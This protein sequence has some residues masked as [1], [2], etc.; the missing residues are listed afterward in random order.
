MLRSSRL[1][2]EYKMLV[3]GHEASVALSEAGLR[4]SHEISRCCIPGVRSET[5]PLGEI[6]SAQVLPPHKLNSWIL[7]TKTAHRLV[8]C[9]FRRSKD[10]PAVWHPRKITLESSHEGVLFKWAAFI[11]TTVAAEQHRP[12]ALLVIIN[13]FGGYKK[14]GY[15]WSSM[16]APVFD[17]AGIRYTVLQTKFGG[18]ARDKLMQMSIEE[19]S[20]IDGIVAIGG[21]GIFHEIVNALLELRIEGHER[22]KLAMS[23]RVGHIPAGSTDA[24]ACTLNGTRSA[25]SAAMHIALGDATPLDVL[26]IDTPDGRHDFSMCMCSYGFMGDLMKESE[27]MRWLGPLRYDVLGAKMLLSNRAY[28]VK[29]SFLPAESLGMF[30][31]RPCHANCPL[32]STTTSS[33]GTVAIDATTSANMTA[34][35]SSSTINPQLHHQSPVREHSSRALLQ[36]KDEWITVEGE[37]TGIMLVIMPCR[38]PKSSKGVAKYGHLSDGT[39]HLVMV[40]RCSRLTYFRFLLHMSRVG[41]EEGKHL[42]GMV[43]VKR[44]VAVRIETQGKES[45]WN[46]DGELLGGDRPVNSFT[47]EVH[48]GAIDVFARGV[49]T[50]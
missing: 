50:W 8:L 32:C 3:D 40:K 9:S 7:F 12:K 31:S 45:R 23:L 22:G 44:A 15:L 35:F 25:F 5:L 20:S 10:N 13:P 27:Q 24:V 48:R 21:D 18:H 2:Q 47:A 37:F 38:S 30:G 39:I 41:L 17:K 1:E 33:N 14:A 46:V 34:P 36:R 16:V 4:W 42:G 49:E 11:N 28:K 26:R 43:E 29:I 19:L 6:L